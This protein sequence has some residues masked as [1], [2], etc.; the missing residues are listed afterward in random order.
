[1]KLGR[2]VFVILVLAVFWTCFAISRH[3][4]R[5]PAVD[6]RFEVPNPHLTP[7]EVRATD[8]DTI[9]ATEREAE[10]GRPGVATKDL[11]WKEYGYVG[12]HDGAHWEFDHLV[13]IECG[14]SNDVRNLWPE[15]RTGPYN[16]YDKD[17]L[18]DYCGDAIRNGSMTVAAAQ[19]VFLEPSDWRVEYR[20]VYGEPADADSGY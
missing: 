9:L 19:A 17:R 18:E 15:P 7:G 16:A 2:L 4:F 3:A 12:R 13:P 5:T 8:L 10:A 1:M 11:V 14:G 20:K 6:D